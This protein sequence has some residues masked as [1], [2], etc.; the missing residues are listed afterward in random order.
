MRTIG[1][2]ILVVLSAHA[3]TIKVEASADAVV[4]RSPMAEGN[5]LMRLPAGFTESE[6][7]VP[8]QKVL[9]KGEAVVRVR[10]DKVDKNL[11]DLVC[12]PTL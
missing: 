7:K 1:F 3:D 11:A 12:P 5:F 4:V 6:A 2:L 9:G 10:I 8:W